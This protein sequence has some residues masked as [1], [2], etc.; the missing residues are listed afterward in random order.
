M[1]F[2][3]LLE[4]GPHAVDGGLA[5]ELEAR[6]HELSDTLWSA[7][8]LADQPNEVLAVHRSYLDAGARVLV[9][10]SYQVSR[11]G[12]VASGRVPEAADDALRTSVALARQAAEGSGVLVA[13]SVGPYG[14]ILHDGSEYRGHY[15]VSHDRLVEF[16]AERLAVLV[17]AGPDL[18]AI[19]TIPDTDEL[20][21]IVEVLA[22]YPGVPAWVS[23]SCRD[24]ETTCAGQPIEAAAQIAGESPTVMAIG[25]NCTAPE[26]VASLLRRLST[27]SD[28]ALLAYPNTGRS[29]D[30]QGGWQGEAAPEDMATVRD[31]ASIE[32]VRLIGGCCGVGPATIAQISETLSA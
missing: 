9:T 30:P 25:V 5:T 21:A 26:H 7:R 4:S 22:A 19:E 18:L 2:Q 11:E 6:G 1:R 16:H 12:F 3:D 23:L 32:G 17:N 14:A 24:G 10:A 8:V 29:F 28:L 20:S 13:A 27:T 31:W 15:G